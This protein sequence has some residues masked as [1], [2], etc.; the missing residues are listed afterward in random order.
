MKIF[1]RRHT[2]WLA[3]ALL[4]PAFFLFFHFRTP[5]AA[6][7]LAADLAPY[8]SYLQSYGVSPEDVLS[9]TLV[10]DGGKTTLQLTLS[11]GG[12]K[13]RTLSISVKSAH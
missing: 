12:E 3:L 13:T 7:S 10:E 11:S 1:H 9:Y 5:D 4:I 2:I 6:H 8:Q